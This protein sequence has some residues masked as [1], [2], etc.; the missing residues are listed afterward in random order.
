MSN[1]LSS[2]TFIL[3]KINSGKMMFDKKNNIFY[4]DKEGNKKKFKLLCPKMK[5]PFGIEKYNK[6]MIV[7]L[8]MDENK[9]YNFM[10]V[11]K[12]IDA[13]FTDV[14]KNCEYVSNYKDRED[15]KPLLRTHLKRY[16]K[17]KIEGV[18]EKGNYITCEL[19]LASMW[20]YNGKY[21]IKWEINHVWF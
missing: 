10:A 14:L 13:Y 5:T 12:S 3:E 20:E 11:L 9:M 6:K 18:I 21:G 17:T 16:G 8:E 7:N 15:F 19:E 4:F 1:N 2:G